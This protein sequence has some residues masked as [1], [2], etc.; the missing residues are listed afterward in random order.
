M[1]YLYYQLH[2]SAST[3]AIVE[4]AFNLTRDYTI[5]MVYSGNG[6]GGG[7]RDLVLQ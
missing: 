4:L 3:L 7:G 6:G 1:E 2:V 5:C